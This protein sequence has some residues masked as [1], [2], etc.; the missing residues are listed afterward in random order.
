MSNDSLLKTFFVAI[1]VCVVCATLVSTANVVLRP[2]I[3]QN[4]LNF[5]HGNIVLAAGLVKPGYKTSEI[6]SAFAK[7]D[8]QIY[9]LLK[10][11]FVTDAKDFN[12][13][14]FDER[15]MMNNDKFVTIPEGAVKPGVPLVPRYVTIYLI[16]D[17]DGGLDKVVLPFFGKGLWSTMY[18]FVSLDKDLNTISRLLYYDQLETAG[19]GGEVE[20][21]VWADKWIGKKAYDKDGKPKIKI[22]KGVVAADDKD[23]PYKVDGIS[24]ATMTCRGVNNSL[25]YWLFEYKGLL[26]T[27]KAGQLPPESKTLAADSSSDNTNG[28]TK[29]TNVK[30]GKQ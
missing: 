2:R 5:K 13:K 18:G 12:V 29:Q 19:L 14:K 21:P 30:G 17:K 27:L 24:G 11:K 3:E 10:E 22:I 1:V 8:A 20:N 16:K 28:N 15:L 6:E 26:D 25:E 23:N 7:C 4:K 9:D